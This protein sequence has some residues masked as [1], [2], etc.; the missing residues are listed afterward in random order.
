VTVAGWYSVPR[1]E[2]TRIKPKDQ[3][4]PQGVVLEHSKIKIPDKLNNEDWG[5]V[6]TEPDTS[7]SAR[8]TPCNII[9]YM[10]RM[11]N[12]CY[13]WL[14]SA[15]LINMTHRR[16]EVENA[17]FKAHRCFLVRY[18]AA[19]RAMSNTPQSWIQSEETDNHPLILRGNS[20]I[21]W[22]R[23]LESH[24]DRY[25]G[26]QSCW[27]L[28]KPYCYPP[29]PPFSQSE[30]S[31]ESVSWRSFQLRTSIVW[32]W[33]KVVSLNYLIACRTLQASWISSSLLKSYHWLRGSAW[34][35][36]RV[37]DLVQSK[38]NLEQVRRIGLD[39]YFEIMDPTE[40]CHFPLWRCANPQ[41]G[42]SQRCK[43]CQGWQWNSS[44]F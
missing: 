1:W 4:D 33:W 16:H 11:K 5:R 37:L 13:R 39:A 38:P 30:R 29:V 40:L 22:T 17:M 7:P 25:L 18:S 31:T 26:G 14:T 34:Q 41:Q 3:I 28:W 9:D 10:S 27:V 20:A 23:L 43:R 35:G 32:R 42:M 6:G 15:Y 21:G 36:G 44:S 2:S 8:S 24:C 19:I 12:Q